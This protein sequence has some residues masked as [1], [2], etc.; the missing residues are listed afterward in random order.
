MKHY[1]IEKII[2]VPE[3]TTASLTPVR[4]GKTVQI[5]GPKGELVRTF[6][7]LKVQLFF[8]DNKFVIQSFFGNKAEASMVGTI[9]GHLTN[10]IKGVTEGFTYKVRVITSH[11]PATVEIQEQEQ[12]IYVKN[13]YGRRDPIRIPFDK[14][15][16]ITVKGDM[17]TMTGIDIE[18]VSQ[19]AA[20]LAE[21]TRLRGRRSKD[22]TVFQDGLYVV[23]P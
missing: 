19:A 7:Q 14:S 4:G 11:F 13:L 16:K 2:E 17:V 1:A 22:P 21:A 6:K 9:A 3:N 12:L 18:K 10:M 8:I 20:R 23:Y 15:V 5:K